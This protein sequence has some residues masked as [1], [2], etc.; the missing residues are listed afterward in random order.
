M[1]TVTDV[2]VRILTCEMAAQTLTAYAFDSGTPGY[3]VARPEARN[4]HPGLMSVATPWLVNRVG[5]NFGTSKTRASMIL[6]AGDTC[7]RVPAVLRSM[8]AMRSGLYDV[9]TWVYESA[10]RIAQSGC[11][12]SANSAILQ[13]CLSDSKTRNHEMHR[14]R[15]LS[16]AV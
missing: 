1:V 13:T 15:R 3:A 10:Q 2:A 7:R 12:F 9:A 5:Q 4:A 16:H 11:G 14:S 8:P 6:A